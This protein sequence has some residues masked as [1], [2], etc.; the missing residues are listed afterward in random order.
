MV[1]VASG[2]S[3]SLC[4]CEEFPFVSL[5]TMVWIHERVC[6]IS[7]DKESRSVRRPR[8][9][10]KQRIALDYWSPHALPGVNHIAF[11]APHTRGDHREVLSEVRVADSGHSGV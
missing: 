8:N 11:P 3:H 10:R 2:P 7:V 1:G 4:V 6:G 5:G 9:M